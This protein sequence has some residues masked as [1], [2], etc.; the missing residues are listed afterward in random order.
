MSNNVLDQVREIASDLFNV[1]AQ[2]LGPDSSPDTVPDWDSVQHL[3]LVLTLEQKFNVQF[4]PED[5]EQM[6]TLSAIA[7]LVGKRMG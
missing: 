3:N 2:Q 4:G 6:R 5:I 1:P 7:D